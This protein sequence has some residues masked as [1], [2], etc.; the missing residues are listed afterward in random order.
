MLT[1]LYLLYKG[2][3]G[4][5]ELCWYAGAIAEQ[6]FTKKSNNENDFK[7]LEPIKNKSNLINFDFLK[8]STNSTKKDNMTTAL[9]II[10][11]Y[12]KY[13]INLQYIKEIEGIS[14]DSLYFKIIS[15]S[16]MK[17]IENLKNDL[18]LFIK[19][20]N[21]EILTNIEEGLIA[22]QF[23]K[24]DKNILSLKDVATSKKEGLTIGLGLTPTNEKIKIDIT[25]TPHLLT[26]GATGSGKSVFLNSLICQL[27]AK[28]T[29]QELN[30]LLIDPKQIELSIYDDIP[31]LL[32][33]IITEPEETAE[34]LEFLIE[35]ME[36]R[37]ILLNEHSAR[38]LED[39][40]RK[41]TKKM[42][43]IVLIF[44]EFADF[45]LTNKKVFEPLITKLTQKAR[46]AGIHL[47]LTTQRP[48]TDVITGLIKANTPSRIAFTTSNRFDSQTILGVK[49][50]ESLNG[51][52][53]CLYKEN[54]KSDLIRCQTPF[55]SIEEIEKIINKIKGD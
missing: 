12:L 23:P 8:S 32:T 53:D 49:G 37:Y 29:P 13:K 38:S 24:N 30:L 14:S 31:H 40:N 10:Q 41:A 43:Y 50:A 48:S 21:I 34:V 52:G 44:D 3:F 11:F 36:N 46:A 42:P 9:S 47:I 16:K 25:Q 28:Y 45:M 17:Q 55:L 39:Y 18:Q 54:G 51:A 22:F 4:F 20:S 27:I 35:E 7:T 5:F 33:P 19:I 6:F 15:N 2:F 26:A 1:I